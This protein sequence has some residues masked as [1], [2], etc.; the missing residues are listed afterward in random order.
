MFPSLLSP[1]QK[2]SVLGIR[3]GF[4]PWEEWTTFPTHPQATFMK[5][6]KQKKKT[7][8]SIHERNSK[9]RSIT[10]TLKS[11]NYSS[12]PRFLFCSSKGKVGGGLT[13]FLVYDFGQAAAW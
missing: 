11:G 8:H 10:S 2:G 1:G 3:V 7:A 6:K 9:R 12:H 13:E 5:K 4:A